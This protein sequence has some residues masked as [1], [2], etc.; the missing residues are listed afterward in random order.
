MTAE[1]AARIFFDLTDP[2][3]L[4]K[5]LFKAIHRGYP[6]SVDRHC[7]NATLDATLFNVA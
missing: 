6:T 7:L 5:N 4:L 3:L 2:H 1:K